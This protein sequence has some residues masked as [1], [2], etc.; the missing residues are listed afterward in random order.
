V[1]TLALIKDTFREAIARKI[2]V[3]LFALATL[4]I[5]FLLF[6]MRIDLVEGALVT[7][8][9]FGMQGRGTQD[10][11][12]LIQG[13]FSAVSGFLY[14]VGMFLAVFAS[15]GLIPSVL[16]P[17]RIELI[18]SKPV[19]R[20]H[21][22]LGRYLGNVLIV[23]FI[24]SYLVIGV[25]LILSIKTGIWQT[26]FLW[27]IFFTVSLFSVL[28]ALVVLTG[29]LWESTALSTMIVVAVMIMSPILAQEKNAV[30]LLSSEWSRNVWKA[31]YYT[32]PKIYD[33]AVLTINA[34]RMKPIDNWWALWTSALFGIAALG[35]ALWVFEKRDY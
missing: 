14:T 33:S 9:L 35:A 24:V 12:R 20:V 3:G 27:T 1:V 18:L 7:V 31:L 8:S 26:G 32:L 28:L 15:A 6:V 17:G 2:F 25:W 30:K 23:L 21:I 11:S 19:S 13:V 5:L 4:L 22:L 10:A 29:V 34:A 16:E